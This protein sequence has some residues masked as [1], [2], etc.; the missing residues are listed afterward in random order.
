M[1]VQTPSEWIPDDKN[2]V[3]LVEGKGDEYFFAKFLE[4]LGKREKVHIVDCKG[5]D[6]LATK[7]SNILNDDNFPTHYAYW[8]S[9]GQ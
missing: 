8:H 4:H 2:R 6:Q 1:T 5:K 7:L 9:A 3:L